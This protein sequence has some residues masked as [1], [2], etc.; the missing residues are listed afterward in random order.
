MTGYGAFWSSEPAG[1]FVRQHE[2]ERVASAQE[3]AERAADLSTRHGYA[4]VVDPD[5]LV[6]TY[7]LG[8]E[9]PWGRA[10]PVEPTGVS[11]E[12]VDKPEVP[13]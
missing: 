5:D 7:E 6:T 9:S 1:R 2:A 8:H 3:A 12:I 13:S 11:S 10:A 4:F